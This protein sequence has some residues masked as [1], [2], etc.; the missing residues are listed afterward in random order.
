MKCRQGAAPHHRWLLGSVPENHAVDLFE[1]G[2]M[3]YGSTCWAHLL[4][5]PTTC[6]SISR[7]LKTLLGPQWGGV[8]EPTSLRRMSTHLEVTSHMKRS[9][10]LRTAV[11][12]R[13]RDLSPS[14]K[15]LVLEVV[16]G[17]LPFSAG[18]W[19]DMHIP[20]IPIV[21]GYSITSTPAMLP[22]LELAVKASRHP[23][24]AWVT[25]EAR[26][27]DPVSLRVG[28][29]F[30]LPT[31]PP[32]LVLFIGGGVGINPLYSM[33]R[34]IAEQKAGPGAVRAA[35]MLYSAP[36]SDEILFRQ[37]LSALAEAQ[38]GRLHVDMCTTRDSS[39]RVD[40]EAIGA[41]VS[42]LRQRGGAHGGDELASVEVYVC[43]PRG[44]AEQMVE[45]C[46]ACGLPSEAVKFEKWW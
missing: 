27:G 16:D 21:G 31:P 24:A 26:V 7:A 8:L 33:M 23:P 20:G 19:V 45:E 15:G 13:I 6:L 3:E 36:T 14:T 42:W 37:E 46:V 12:R 34:S 40:R 5:Y 11:V 4:G 32:P 18:Q 17:E 30:G 9:S 41:A 2:R 10:T 39:R 1:R 35:A 25:G 29:S 22:L 43:G 28:G 38:P 44:M